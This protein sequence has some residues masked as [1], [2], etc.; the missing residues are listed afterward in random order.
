MNYLQKLFKLRKLASSSNLDIQQ[1][2]PVTNH[3]C[4]AH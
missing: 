4:Q 2:A 3:L 1:L